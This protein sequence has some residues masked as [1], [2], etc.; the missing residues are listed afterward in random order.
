M[1]KNLEWTGERLVTDVQGVLGVAEHLHRYALA[2]EFVKGKKVLDIASGEGYGSNLLSKH[3]EH[4]TGVDI[5]DDA[6]KHA[7]EKY[8][9]ESKLI[10]RVGSASKIPLEDASVGVVTSFETLEHTTEHDEFLQEIKRV[11]V[12]GGL[13]IMST[14]DTVLYKPHDP[15]NPYHLKELTTQEFENLIGR[16]F[17]NSILLNQRSVIGT[18]VQPVSISVDGFKSFSGEYSC[19]GDGYGNDEFYGKPLFNIAIASDS[20]INNTLIEKATLF[21]YVPDLLNEFKG[22]IGLM[23]ELQE[24]KKLA[25]R[26]EELEKSKSYL[27]AQRISKILRLFEKK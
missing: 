15:N 22:S 12:P 8:A 27:F 26:L 3:A 4:V 7:N 13:L 9:K 6:V 21:N 20:E 11:L 18:L 25:N 2:C 10:Y 23:F 14:P 19:V 16:Y 1:D 5:S 17:Q 24:L